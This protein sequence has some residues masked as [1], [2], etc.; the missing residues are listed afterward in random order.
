[1]SRACSTCEH[2]DRASIEIGLANGIALRVLSKRYGLDPS[3]MSRHRTN[4]MDEG[5]LARLR[6]RGSRSD[7]E[8]AEIRDVEAKGLLDNF[9]TIRGRLYVNADRCR[10]IGD[11][12]GERQAMAE[13]S[14]VSEKIGKLLGELGQHIRVE[15]RISLVAMPEWHLIRQALVRELVPLGQ[16]AIAAGAR[17]LAAAESA[18]TRPVIEHQAA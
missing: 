11:D 4:H 17:A 2:P 1:M 6:V 13:A 14:K 7:A 15:H 18:V 3:Q 8:L 16:D 9:V 12:L 5:L 10:A